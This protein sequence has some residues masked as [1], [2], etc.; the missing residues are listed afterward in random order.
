MFIRL[1]HQNPPD[2]VTPGSGA[3]KGS[4]GIFFSSS[5]SFF[6][7]HHYL[8]ECRLKHD[9]GVINAIKTQCVR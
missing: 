6:A 2:P 9:L 7:V 8:V 1:C 5:H 4:T 3:G